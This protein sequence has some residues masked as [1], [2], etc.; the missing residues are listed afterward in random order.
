LIVIGLRDEFLAALYFMGELIPNGGDTSDTGNLEK[1]A[2]RS[3]ARNSGKEPQRALDYC[4]SAG[5]ER[6]A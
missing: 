6:C 4:D 1:L 2:V 5:S 3:N